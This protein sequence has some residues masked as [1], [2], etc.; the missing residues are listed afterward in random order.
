MPLNTAQA[1]NIIA[2]RADCSHSD[3][4]LRQNLHQHPLD[5]RTETCAEYLLLFLGISVVCCDTLWNE[6]KSDATAADA[7]S[8]ATVVCRTI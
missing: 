5:V 4:V 7:R 1:S 2:V 6:L 8:R 3:A